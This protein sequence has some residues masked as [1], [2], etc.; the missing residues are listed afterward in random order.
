[1]SVAIEVVAIAVEA[2]ESGGR[3]WVQ[4]GPCVG[5]MQVN[6]R[7]SERTRAALFDPEVNRQEGRKILTY[8]LH[9]SHGNWHKALAAY[10]CGNAGLRDEC[11][12][13][14][15]R[16]VWRLVKSQEVKP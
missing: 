13:A 14:Y 16:K 8:W 3:W 5:V 2:V 15:A 1:V 10:N 7:W 6:P 11:G 12:Q 9:R 4:N